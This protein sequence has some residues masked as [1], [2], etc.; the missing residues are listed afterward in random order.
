MSRK[1]WIDHIV[2]ESKKRKADRLKDKEYVQKVQIEMDE[3]YKDLSEVINTLKKNDTTEEPKMKNAYDSLLME[4]KFD[5]SRRATVNSSLL[6]IMCTCFSFQAK[7][8]IKSEEEIIL[9]EKRKLEE[10]ERERLE[11]MKVTARPNQKHQSADALDD[12]L[13][14]FYF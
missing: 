1:E 8:R 10:L 11:S 6:L 3:K 2:A 5:M 7:E 4:L 12:D 9:K 14:V 13:C